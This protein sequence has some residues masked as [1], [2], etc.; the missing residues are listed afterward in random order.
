MCV[1]N[2]FACFYRADFCTT[3]VVVLAILFLN[4]ATDVS[5]DKFRFLPLLQLFSI[6]YDFVWL[7]KVQDMV[8]E[9]SEEGGLEASVRAFS[10]RVSYIALGFKFVAFFVLWKVSYNYLVDIKGIKDAPRMGKV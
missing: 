1:L 5:R 3:L 6:V 4:D 8:N 7:F 10:V 2:C 9:G